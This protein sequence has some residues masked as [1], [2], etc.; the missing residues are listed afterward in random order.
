MAKI[1]FRDEEVDDQDQ[2]RRGDHCLRRG[3][4]DSLRTAAGRHAV[5][6]TDGGDDESE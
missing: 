1:N 6:A 4:T 2:H 5:V 3:S